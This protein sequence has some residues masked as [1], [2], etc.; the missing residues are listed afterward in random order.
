MY[1]YN[2]W[3]LDYKQPFGAIKVGNSMNLSFT[4]DRPS[5][6]VT[7]VIRRDFGK[8]YEFSMTKDSGGNFRVTIPFDEESG[9]YFYHFEIVE[10]SDLGE[11]RRFYG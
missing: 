11:T 6:L 3:N 4:T 8:R 10:S 2:P 5:V 9:L 7:C 1:Y